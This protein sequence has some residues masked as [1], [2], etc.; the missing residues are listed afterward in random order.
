MRYD[1][2]MIDLAL[3]NNANFIPTNFIEI[4]S[5]DGHDTNFIKQHFNIPDNKCYIFEAHPDCFLNIKNT[6][7]TF[8]IFNC[9]ISNKTQPIKFNAGIIGVENNIGCSSILKDTSGGF[10]SNEILIDGWRFDEICTQLDL[11]DIDVVKID[12]EGHTKEVLLG[13]G[14]MLSKT[15][16]LQL[17]LE[18]IECWENQTLYD[19]INKFLIDNGFI[20]IV[21]IRHSYDQSDSFWINQNYIKKK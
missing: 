3:K 1:L 7:P 4:G 12:V 16:S 14:S 10:K 20:E 6:Y 17:E 2:F 11:I 19:D 9:A 15:K 18:H 5:R 8:N 13:F 21:F